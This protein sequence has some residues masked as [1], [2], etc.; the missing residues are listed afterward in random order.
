[1][2]NFAPGVIVN[3]SFLLSSLK[4]L[5]Q[6]RILTNIHFSSSHYV[7][8][9]CLLLTHKRAILNDLNDSNKVWDFTRHNILKLP[10]PVDFCNTFSYGMLNNWVSFLWHVIFS[11]F[12]Q[13]SDG[14]LVK[15]SNKLGLGQFKWNKMYMSHY[16]IYIYIYIYTSLLISVRLIFQNHHLVELMARFDYLIEQI[17]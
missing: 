2:A 15:E 12:L 9:T 10:Q 4:I 7:N 13:T 1:M 16:Y 14:Q 11:R 5:T 6:Y 8:C 17:F 3:I